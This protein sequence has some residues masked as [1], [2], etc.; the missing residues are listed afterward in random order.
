MDELRIR[1][2]NFN[3]RTESPS[4]SPQNV[5]IRNPGTSAEKSVSTQKIEFKGGTYVYCHIISIWAS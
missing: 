4:G 3:V 2:K 1:A 5:R